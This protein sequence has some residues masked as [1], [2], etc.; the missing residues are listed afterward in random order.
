MTLSELGIGSRGSSNKD[1]GN[2]GSSDDPVYPQ[3]SIS[4][5]ELLLPK[6]YFVCGCWLAMIP[7]QVC[8][9]SLCIIRYLYGASVKAVIKRIADMILFVQEF[10]VLFVSWA[11]IYEMSIT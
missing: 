4:C 5:K 6:G 1:L 7:V 10:L 2:L 9:T 8:F 11:I 3:C